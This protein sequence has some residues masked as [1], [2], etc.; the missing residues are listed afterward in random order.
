VHKATGVLPT[1]SNGGANVPAAAEPGCVSAHR[2]TE[3]MHGP[4]PL[5]GEDTQPAATQGPALEG[6]RFPRS[7]LDAVLLIQDDCAD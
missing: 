4:H 2:T 7:Q 3:V 5:G 6:G 1:A